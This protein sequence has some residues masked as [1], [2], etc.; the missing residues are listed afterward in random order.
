MI[1]ISAQYLVFYG[2]LQLQKQSFRAALL[3]KESANTKSLEIK[4]DQLYKDT[5]TFQWREHNKELIIENKFYE[6]LAVFQSAETAVI[7]LIE[8]EKENELLQTYFQNSESHKKLSN[9]LQALLCLIFYPPQELN[10]MPDTKLYSQLTFCYL[11]KK[12]TDFRCFLIKPPTVNLP[13]A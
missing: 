7:T 1:F 6:V 2:G 5:K 10:F 12:S 4:T 11:Y 9:V 3:L 13:F 8:D